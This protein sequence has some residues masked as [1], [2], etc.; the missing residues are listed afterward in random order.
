MVQ[1]VRES[2][3]EISSA[4]QS[5]SSG[6]K[7]IGTTME[8]IDDMTRQNAMMVD[9]ATG[10]SADLEDK[11]NALASAVSRFEFEKGGARHSRA[12]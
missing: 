2:I 4:A 1:G 12:A 8:T 7:E 3:S 5:Q 11:A 6:V 10:T 9:A